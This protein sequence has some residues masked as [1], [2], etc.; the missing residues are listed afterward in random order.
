MTLRKHLAWTWRIAAAVLVAA[1]APAALAA[2]GTGIAGSKH[3]FSTGASN[4]AYGNA[5]AGTQIC[6][7]CH[8]PHNNASASGSLL[9]NRLQGAGPYTMYTNTQTGTMNGV[10]AGPGEVSKLC[11][12]CHDGTIAVDNYG[13][14]NGASTKKIT[15]NA[16]LGTDLSNDHPIG[17][18]YTPATATTD[19]GL[20]NPDTATV[21]LAGNAAASITANMLF[22]TK[23]ECASCHDVH[24]SAKRTSDTNK[25][26]TVSIGASALCTTCHVK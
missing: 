3:D 9:W 26:L 7:Y 18:V 23:V 24:S 2:V 16:K 12:S 21:A 19:G 4:T 14:I 20:K 25:L 1:A 5:S 10:S 22:M 8:A 6:I 17:I 11:L 13:G 15:N